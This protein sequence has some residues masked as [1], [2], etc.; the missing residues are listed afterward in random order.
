MDTRILARI[1]AVAFVAAI[2]AA[3][4]VE[5]SRKEDTPA[6]SEAR[7]R[8]FE[9]SAQ[10]ASQR[11]CQELGQKAAE[12]TECLRVWALTRDRFLGR[13]PAPASSPDP[14]R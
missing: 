1:G 8:Q 9:E 12:D 2:S 13:A 4:A 3:I 5:M 14:A 10:R 6:P 7:P 11:R